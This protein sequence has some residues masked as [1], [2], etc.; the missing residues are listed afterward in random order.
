MRFAAQSKCSRA[1]LV[2]QEG[3]LSGNA[4]CLQRNL[5][6]LATSISFP[7]LVHLPEGLLSIHAYPPVVILCGLA[8]ITAVYLARDILI[9]IAFAIFVAVLLRLLMRRMRVLHL[10]DLVSAL[11]T[12]GAGPLVWRDEVGRPGPGLAEL[13]A[14]SAPQ[15]K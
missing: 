1:R 8:V 11:F 15:S 5:E 9:P 10:P 6:C 12:G 14:P 2:M 13:S 7:R 3:C 4:Q